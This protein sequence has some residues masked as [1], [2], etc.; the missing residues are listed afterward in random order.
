MKNKS[1]KGY[2]KIIR[3]EN[4]LIKMIVMKKTKITLL[5]S[6]KKD[7]LI[8]IRRLSNNPKYNNYKSFN[9]I[10]KRTN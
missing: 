6:K 10:S 4:R 7:K 2:K 5:A 1:K 9:K 3:K 8:K